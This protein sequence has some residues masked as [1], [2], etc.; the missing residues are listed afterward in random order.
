VNGDAKPDVVVANRAGDLV[1][2]TVD[3]LL[4]NGDGTLRQAVPYD[5]GGAI[6]TGI[7]VAD[8]NR[9][10]KPDLIVSNWIGFIDRT[11]GEVRKSV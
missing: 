8:L 10:D 9:D 3:V 1:D 2:R 4:G 5:A 6:A 11:N 7:A